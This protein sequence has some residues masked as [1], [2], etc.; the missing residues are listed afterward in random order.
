MTSTRAVS[1]SEGKLTDEQFRAIVT[2]EIM[3]AEAEGKPVP[4]LKELA[5]KTGYGSPGGVIWRMRKLG[6]T[7]S[8]KYKVA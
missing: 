5:A 3:N 8:R 2:A 4:T 1:A 7:M 6:I